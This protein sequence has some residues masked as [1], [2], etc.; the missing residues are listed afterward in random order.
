MADTMGT[1]EAS[2]KWGYSQTTIA[3]WCKE[4]KIDGATQYRNRGPWAIPTDAM[5]PKPIKKKGEMK[6]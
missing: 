6:K 5:C 1:R 4:G 3:I 2:E